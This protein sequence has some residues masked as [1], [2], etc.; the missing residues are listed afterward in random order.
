MKYPVFLLAFFF[1][2]TTLA[3]KAQRVTVI[4]DTVS[5]GCEQAVMKYS[6]KV[7][8]TL[9]DTTSILWDF[10]KNSVGNDTISAPTV[11]YSSSGIYTVKVTINKVNIGDTTIVIPSCLAVPNVFTPNNDGKNDELNIEYFGSGNI[12][13]TVFTR[14]GIKIYNT[15][16]NKISWDGHLDNGELVAPGIYY[17]V[18]DG[19][20]AKPPVTKKGFFYVFY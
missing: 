16:G 18:I 20:N 11:H 3:L 6:F 17:Y 19:K 13:F 4:S 14:A 10:G 7:T 12:S 5:V 2:C 1:N 9:S 8:P 15:E